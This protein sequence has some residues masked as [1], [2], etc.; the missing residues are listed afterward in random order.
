MLP[1]LD[2]RSEIYD[3]ADKYGCNI[4]HHTVEDHR[5][6]LI[7][8]NW[9]D[10]L[11]YK[12][13]WMTR[14]ELVDVSYESVRRLTILKNKYGMMPDGIT[15]SICKLIGSTRSLLQKIDACQALPHSE[16]KMIM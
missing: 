14:E 1:F 7:S 4:F 2:P 3:N 8:L 9:K 10:R 12:T 13:K 15:Q 11:N 5:N 6:A 16:M